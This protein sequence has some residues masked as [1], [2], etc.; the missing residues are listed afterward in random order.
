MRLFVVC[1]ESQNQKYWFEDR[2]FMKKGRFDLILRFR[3]TIHAA[4]ISKQ[5]YEHVKHVRT[6]LLAILG[7]IH[8]F[9][10]I[11]TQLFKIGS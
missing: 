7:R 3:R 1:I 4:I 6:N 10:F 11:L 2:N 8:Y 5:H 9:R